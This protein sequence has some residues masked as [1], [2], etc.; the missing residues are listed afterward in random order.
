MPEPNLDYDQK[1]K[2]A[3]RLECAICHALVY[4]TEYVCAS[5]EGTP[6][7]AGPQYG[8]TVRAHVTRLMWEIETSV[9]QSFTEI[10]SGQKLHPKVREQL[11]RRLAGVQGNL[12]SISL[13][14]QAGARE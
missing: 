7:E 3:V 2:A 1:Q 5:C 9:R 11:W 14:L 12:E 8:V 4:A 10:R 13:W 6:P